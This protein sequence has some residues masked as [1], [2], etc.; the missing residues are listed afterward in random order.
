MQAGGD[1]TQ[2]K[3]RDETER[4]RNEKSFLMFH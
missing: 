2:R 1:E 4:E 3:G